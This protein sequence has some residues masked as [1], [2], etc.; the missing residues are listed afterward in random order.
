MNR[1]ILVL[2]IDG[3]LVNDKKEIT[4]KTKEKLM[5][6]QKANIVSLSQVARSIRIC[7]RPFMRA[8]MDIRFIRM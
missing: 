6:M 5:E 2:D 3:T 7:S 8:H 4:P 1:K